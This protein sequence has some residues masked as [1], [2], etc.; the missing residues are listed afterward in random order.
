MT[1]I[2]ND[3]IILVQRK[4]EL[5]ILILLQFQF[6]IPTKFNPIAQTIQDC[7]TNKRLSLTRR[8][9][10]SKHLCS[11]LHQKLWKSG[12]KSRRDISKFHSFQ[13]SDFIPI[14]RLLKIS[15]KVFEHNKSRSTSL[16][17]QEKD[18]F[19]HNVR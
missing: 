7:S 2:C 9:C 5:R 10:S 19:L 15:K 3:Q 13:T 12:Q 18:H 1:N 8:E 4:L 11:K 17:N 14:K 6:R 16:N